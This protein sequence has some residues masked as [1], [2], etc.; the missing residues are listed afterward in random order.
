MRDTMTVKTPARPLPLSN[1]VWALMKP[2]KPKTL[3]ID[4]MTSSSMAIGCKI[5]YSFRFPSSLQIPVNPES[6]AQYLCR[7]PSK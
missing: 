5:M 6:V 4:M 2:L 3:M 7:R 1:R